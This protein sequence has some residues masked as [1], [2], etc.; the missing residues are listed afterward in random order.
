MH[1][2]DVH[3]KAQEINSRKLRKMQWLQS[4]Q[5][6]FQNRWKLL[7]AAG[8]LELASTVDPAKAIGLNKMLS[9]VRD[10]RG[11][12]QHYAKQGP[13]FCHCGAGGD[14]GTGTAVIIV[15][16]KLKSMN[17]LIGWTVE[18]VTDNNLYI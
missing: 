18:P 4:L 6:K 14:L 2:S 1:K 9:S 16:G 10:S 3:A 12:K 11:P 15:Q 8:E 13:R 5:K 7:S 17:E